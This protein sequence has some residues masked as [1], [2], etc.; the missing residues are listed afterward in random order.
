MMFKNDNTF[1]DSDFTNNSADTGGAITVLGGRSKSTFSSC[2]FDS[3]SAKFTGALSILGGGSVNRFESCLFGEQN[4]GETGGAVYVAGGNIT[5]FESCTFGV[6]EQ[7]K[8]SSDI[9]Y[10][11]RGKLE[12]ENTKCSNDWFPQPFTT[13][14]GSRMCLTRCVAKGGFLHWPWESIRPD[15]T[16]W[17]GSCDEHSGACKCHDILG[18]EIKLFTGDN[19]KCEGTTPTPS[20]F[21]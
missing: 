11:G 6:I 17:Y 20:L 3:N 5:R 4:Q 14:S 12:F 18:T 9:G 16:C 13:T 19:C 1:T 2:Q 10:L 21:F 15:T 8:T 7:I